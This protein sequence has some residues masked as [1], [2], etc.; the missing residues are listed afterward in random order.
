MN[1]QPNTTAR[2]AGIA[3]VLVCLVFAAGAQGK[4]TTLSDPTQRPH[5]AGDCAPQQRHALYRLHA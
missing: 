2:L 1:T 4:E 3:A 5:D